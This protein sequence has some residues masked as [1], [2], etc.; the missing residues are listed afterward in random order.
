[1]RLLREMS[2]TPL[3]VPI[4]SVIG[5]AP[6]TGTERAP[7]FLVLSFKDLNGAVLLEVVESGGSYEVHLGGNSG[8]DTL[9]RSQFVDTLRIAVG[10][11]VPV[12]NDGGAALKTVLLNTLTNS[13]KTA[14]PTSITKAK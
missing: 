11:H 3:I 12:P 13:V 5:K 2:R 10:T 1:L 4:R 14:N 6:L 7:D 8:L 9:L